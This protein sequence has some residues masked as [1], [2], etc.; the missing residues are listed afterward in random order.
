MNCNLVNGGR[1]HTVQ[2]TK[3]VSYAAGA[4]GYDYI[5]NIDSRIT[6][7]NVRNVTINTPSVGALGGL[8]LTPCFYNGVG[9]MYYS[10]YSPSAINTSFEL[11]ITFED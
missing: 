4:C 5:D 10:Y 3:S 8:Q 9:Y 2:Y 6:A 1:L 7:A 11:V